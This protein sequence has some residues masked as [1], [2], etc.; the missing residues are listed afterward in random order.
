[1]A[2]CQW[3]CSRGSAP[4]AI[5]TNVHSCGFTP[6][7]TPPR[8]GEGNS[9]G[10]CR[11][12]PAHDRPPL[13]PAAGDRGN[14]GAAGV[15]ASRRHLLRHAPGIERCRDPGSDARQHRLGAVLRLVRAGGRDARG[16]WRAR[17][18]VR[19]DPARRPSARRPDVGP[20]P[21]P[22][23]ARTESGG[24]GSP[25]MRPRTRQRTAAH[26]SSALWIAF[27]VHRLSGLALAA[28]LPLHFLALGLAIDGEARL[29]GFLRWTANPLVKLV[30]TVL[31]FLLVV[32]MLGGIRVLVIENLP[33][34]E[35]QKRIAMVALAA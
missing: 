23:S 9:V 33:W 21:G 8:Q 10:A 19:V 34:H 12:G 29:D 25:V 5:S 13:C 7:L 14:H 26:R 30:E 17:G 16:H 2:P 1:M 22:G 4:A 32:H 3:G 35:G 6:P 27:L 28:F 20:G 31:V 11:S 24:G 15:G 18:G